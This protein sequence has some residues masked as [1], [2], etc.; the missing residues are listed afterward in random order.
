MKTMGF[1]YVFISFS[2]GTWSFCIRNKKTQKK[3]LQKK[4]KNDFSEKSWKMIRFAYG[5]KN[6]ILFIIFSITNQESKPRK[7]EF[8]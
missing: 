8:T 4:S 6:K 5:K 7:N 1:A 3:K 2:I